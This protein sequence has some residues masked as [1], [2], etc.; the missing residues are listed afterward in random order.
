MVFSFFLNKILA[1]KIY[2]NVVAYNIILF[3]SQK[4]EQKEYFIGANLFFYPCKNILLSV[5]WF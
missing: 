4:A 5:C 3:L 1:G 2:S